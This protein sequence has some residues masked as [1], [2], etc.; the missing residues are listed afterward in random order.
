MK[1][2]VYY[3]LRDARVSE[4][5]EPELKDDSVKIAVSYCGICGTDIHK[6]NGKGG[7]RPVIPP[8]VLGHEVSGVVEKVGKKVT[9]FK[10]GDRVTADPNWSCGSCYYCQR[11]LTHMCENSAGV[12]KGMA[13]YICPPEKNVYKVPDGYPLKYAALTEPLSCCLHGIDLAGIQ[14]GDN[15]IIVGMGAMGAMMVELARISGANHIIVVEPNISKKTRAFKLGAT[16]FIDPSCENVNQ[17]IK[18]SDIKNID[19]VIECVGLKQTMENALSYAGKCAT[20]VLFGLGD[21]EHPVSF[22]QYEAFKKEL[23][24]KTSFVNPNVSQRA[25]DLLVSGKVDAEKHIVHVMEME[26]VPKELAEKTYF[27]KGKVLVKVSGKEK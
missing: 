3:G 23:V 21:P 4:F 12:V 11:G 13:E 20:V 14:T 2:V 24:I 22:N 16:M 1:A 19:K 25:L 7:S 26:D 6:F 27:S 8:V 10:A 5:K 17:T 15:I 18:E 9:E